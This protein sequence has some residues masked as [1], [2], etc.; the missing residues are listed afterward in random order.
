MKPMNPNLTAALLSCLLLC[1]PFDLHAATAVL[2]RD[3]FEDNTIDSTLWTI[4]TPFA[5]SSA[6]ETDGVLRMTGRGG[7]LANQ[8][9]TF[10]FEIRGSLRI[11]T[12]AEILRIVDRTSG[13]QSNPSGEYDDGI[14][15]TLSNHDTPYVR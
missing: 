15:F 12:G 11:V 4:R 7:L 1:Q 2:L 3:D 13:S 10:P 8:S 9:F 14:A 6:V 5:S